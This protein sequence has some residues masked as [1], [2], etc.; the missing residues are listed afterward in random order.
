MAEYQEISR[1]LTE[2]QNA[3]KAE[4]MLALGGQ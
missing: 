3:L 4:L 1:Q 2:A